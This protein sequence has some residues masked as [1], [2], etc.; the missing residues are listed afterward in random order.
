VDLTLS[1]VSHGHGELL[2]A[3]LSDLDRIASTRVAS[4]ILTLNVPEQRVDPTDYPKL[5]IG[6]IDN[7]VPKGFGANHNAAFRRCTTEWFAVLN[8]D[9]R[10]PVDPFAPLLSSIA[11]HASAALIAPSIIDREGRIED[12]VRTNL[13]P[14]SVFRRR[15]SAR[16]RADDAEPNQSAFHWYAGMFMLFRSSVFRTIGG[17]DER[18]FLY[19]EDY[20]ICARLHLAGYRLL[21]DRN[22]RVVHHARRDSHTSL[23]HLAWHVASLLKIWASAPFW[24]IALSRDQSTPRR[25]P[26]G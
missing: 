23:R 24:R 12:S 5:Q 7:Q 8:P 2:R 20:D 22:T 14:V 16:R 1:I 18:L 25:E 3:L 9:L 19:C 4:V 6:T 26:T 15:L 10:L 21:L 13:S 17:F 11:A